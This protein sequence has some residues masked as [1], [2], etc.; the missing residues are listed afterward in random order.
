L[1][2]AQ[3]KYCRQKTPRTAKRLDQLVLMVFPATTQR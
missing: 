3:S 2:I 1:T